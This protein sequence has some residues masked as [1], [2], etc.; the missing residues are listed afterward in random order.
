MNFDWGFLNPIQL[1]GAS[2]SLYSIAD[3][4]RINPALLAGAG[5]ITR[6]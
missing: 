1:P 6:V 4:F 5:R 3:Y 2:G